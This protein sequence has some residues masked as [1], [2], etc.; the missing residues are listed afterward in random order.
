MK[1]EADVQLVCAGRSYFIGLQ[2][3]VHKNVLWFVELSGCIVRFFFVLQPL[4]GFSECDVCRGRRIFNP[5]RCMR[6]GCTIVKR[7]VRTAMLRSIL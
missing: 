7:A 3:E 4:Q 1:P 6:T 2:F 5:G